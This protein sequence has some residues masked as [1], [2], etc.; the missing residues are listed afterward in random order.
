MASITTSTFDPLR[1]FVNVRLQQGVP[2][3]D[4]DW[5]ELD[6]VPEVRAARIPQ[7]V[8]RRRRSG[9]QRRIPGDTGRHRQRRHHPER[10]CQP[11]RG[12]RRGTPRIAL[13]HVGRALV[14]GLDVMIEQDLTFS[15]QDLLKGK[16]GAE[17]KAKQLDV[18]VIE[19]LTTPAA[20]GPV[21]IYLDVW[22]RLITPDAQP[23]LVLT[24]LGVESCAR[25]RREWVIRS[26][27]HPV[28]PA[29]PIRT[30]CPAMPTFRSPS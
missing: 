28:V 19:P 22:E 29:P 23:S 25:V 16:P 5:N 9:R 15:A 2:I 4:S 26:R 14:D 27:A 10:A 24:G 13:G 20:D 3:V 12:G 7:V 11:S 6:D 8:R 1:R 18:P 30:T 17:A 21:L